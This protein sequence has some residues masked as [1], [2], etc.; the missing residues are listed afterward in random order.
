M[1][2]KYLH[3]GLKLNWCNYNGENEKIKNYINFKT[4]NGKK[5]EVFKNNK[6]LGVFPSCSE[7]ERKSEKLFGVKLLKNKISEVANGKR[8][9][10]KGYIFSYI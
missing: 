5:I 10:Y 8:K 2:L 9:Q 1:L 4:I 6:S 7:L 3:I